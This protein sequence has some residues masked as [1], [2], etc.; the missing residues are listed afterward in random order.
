MNTLMAALA[1]LSLAQAPTTTLT[2]DEALRRAAEA[3]LDLRASQARVTQAKAG[4]WKAWSYYLPQVTAGG[5]WTHN[6]DE[7]KIPLPVAYAVRTRTG[8]PGTPDNPNDPANMPGAAS[9]YFVGIQSQEVTL[10]QHDQLA[11]QIQVTQAIFAPTLWFAIQAA[12]QG[13][14]V[15]VKNVEQ[16]RRDVLFGVAQAYYGVTSLK[17]LVTVSEELLGIAE[18]QE[19]DAK[20]RLEVGTIPKV[21]HLRAQIDRAR[22]EQDLVRARNAYESAR[23]ALAQLLDRDTAFEVAEPAEPPLPPQLSGLEDTA[24]KERPDLQAARY[25]EGLAYA[26]RRSTAAQ[27]LP[28]LGAFYR[29]Q[30]A[31]VSGFTGRDDS[32][33]LGLSLTWT[34]FDG[35]LREATLREASARIVEAEATRRS[36]ET[37]AVAEVK[38]ALLDLESA[39]ANAVKS[40]EQAKLAQENQRLVDVSYKAGAATAVEQADATAQLRTAAIEATADELSAQLASLK[41]LKVAG[42]F[43]PNAR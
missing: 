18:R 35:G 27:Y 33:A 2:L 17:K 23:I 21:G 31:N 11:G 19:R 41:L 43:E 29:Y 6:R 34:L 7:A 14:G 40:R 39:R 10:Q 20:V 38:Q 4:V 42:A 8:L 28:S 30:I 16:A 15:A 24:L 9:P 13:E 5:T 22:A 37:R 26:Q 1:A 12:Y 36:A 3:N 32:W 25:G